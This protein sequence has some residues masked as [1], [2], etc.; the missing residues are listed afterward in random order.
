MVSSQMILR[1]FLSLLLISLCF[2]GTLSAGTEVK[3]KNVKDPVLGSALFHLYQDK[4]LSGIINLTAAQEL[5]RVKLQKEETELA[6]TMLNLAYGLHREAASTMVAMQKRGNVNKDISNTI[7]FY[8]A[9]IRY[10]RGYF[11]M[12]ES[13]LAQISGALPW[14]LEQDLELFKALLLMDRGQF[15]PASKALQMLKGNTG[16]VPFARFNNAVGQVKQEQVDEAIEALKRVTTLKVN[17]LEEKMLADRAN[18]HLG[19]F[20]LLEKEDAETAIGYFEKVHLYGVESNEALLGLGWSHYTLDQYEPA[21][22]AWEELASRNLSDPNVQEAMIAVPFTLAKMENYTISGSLYN[23]ALKAF[24][25]EVER[26]DSTIA[27]VK[28]GAFFDKL[29]TD[30]KEG[31]KG[32]NGDVYAL[33]KSTESYYFTQMLSRHDYQEA[34]KNYRDLRYLLD[35]LDEWQHDVSTFDDTNQYWIRKLRKKAKEFDQVTF[36]KRVDQLHQQR[37]SYMAQLAEVEA[38]HDAMAL[39]TADEQRRLAKVVELKASLELGASSNPQIEEQRRS[40]SLI[41]RRILWDVHSQF[42]SRLRKAKLD[43]AEVVDTINGALAQ[44]KS[45]EKV[46]DQSIANARSFDKRVNDANLRINALRPQIEMAIKDS[47]Q[48]LIN[49]AVMA[50]EERRHKLME[51]IAQVSFSVGVSY[52]RGQ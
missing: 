6:L 14:E 34:L 51:F 37:T 31:E 9:K 40:L 49:I 27:S 1:R 32:W 26:V 39:A 50:L 46:A 47:E 45:M 7:W 16:A 44:Q 10:Q 25:D 43:L 36:Q 12:A 17:T 13:A 5:D 11:T 30:V 22:I 18:V 20:Y 4:N 29:L 38:N 8:I 2:C 48:H 41:E 28:K 21:L 19:Y 15:A 3:W 24:S 42:P 33:P 52:D 23:R 35:K